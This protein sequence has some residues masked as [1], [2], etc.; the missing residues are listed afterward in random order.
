[1]FRLEGIHTPCKLHSE[2]NILDEKRE[3]KV[4]GGNKTALNPAGDS[5]T[6]RKRD[7][8][9]G[10]RLLFAIFYINNISLIEK[11]AA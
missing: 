7:H 4:N 1:L 3:G 6:L 9:G 5:V 10:M 2:E 8:S 11:D